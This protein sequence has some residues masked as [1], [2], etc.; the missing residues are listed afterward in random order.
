M[1]GDTYNSNKYVEK[2]NYNQFYIKIEDV[3]SL[4][5]HIRFMTED[6]IKNMNDV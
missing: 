1:N 6:N 4:N 5:N 3:K 2:R